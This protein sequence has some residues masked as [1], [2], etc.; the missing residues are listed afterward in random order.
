MRLPTLTDW[1]KTVDRLTEVALRLQAVERAFSQRLGP[2]RNH[3]R[4]SSATYSFM[5]RNER[6]TRDLTSTEAQLELMKDDYYALK[7]WD[8]RTGLL[9]RQA[10][11]KLD[12]PDTADR[13]G[14]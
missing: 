13:L 9:T 11:E 4:V 7:G 14:L 5:Q 12:L 10:L 2:G 3:D 6:E 1:S 8:V